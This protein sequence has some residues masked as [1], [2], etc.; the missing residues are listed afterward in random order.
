[1]L[2][3]DRLKKLRN[4]F[5]LTQEE[6]GN[7]INV[8]KASICCYEKG[9]RIPTLQNLIDLSNY[10]EV[11]ID[12]LLGRDVLVKNKITGKNEFISNEE[13]EKIYLT[14]QSKIERKSESMKIDSI[15]EKLKRHEKLTKEEIFYVVN[16]FTNGVIN[17]TKM[18]DF[19]LLIKENGL[20]YE[21]TF[22]LTDAMIKTGDVLDLSNINKTVVDKHSTGGVGDKTTF[23]VGP[24]VASLGL[25]VAKMSGRSLGFTGG[26]IDKLESIPGYTV[27]L[28]NEEFENLVNT[29][30]ISIISQTSSLAPADKKIYALRDEIG[31]VESI[32]LIASSI[33][34]KKIASGAPYIV[35]DLKVGKGAFMKDE[36]SAE[37]LA[38]YMIKIGEYFKR[39][40]VCVLT[41]MST[42]LGYS[43]GN[44]L[45]VKE[46]ENFFLGKREKRLEKLVIELS[47]HMISLGKNISLDEAKKE[48]EKVLT[49]GS[50]KNK[51]YEWI[52]SQHGDL[53]KMLIS[54]KILS[55]KSPKSGYI[56]E[57]NPLEI[58]KIENSLGAGRKKKEDE[59]NRSV[60]INLLHTIYDKIEKDEPL[61]EIYYKDLPADI[62]KKVL[63]LI[64]IESIIEN[65]KDIIISVIK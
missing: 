53:N 19:L 39:K 54:D 40:V 52:N 20:S 28:T 6:L 31:A 50:A 26:T 63:D 8:T 57:I 4:T 3:T 46:A 43:I 16:N 42:P 45:E 33:M 18:G 23:I 7:I 59:I 21:E 64:K 1:M 56:T 62:E 22:Y 35:I 32:P 44:A 51:F 27:N 49:N 36:S 14:Q 13:L 34:S 65:E 41:D 61:M 2:A 58:S 17:D 60:G 24:I 11:S 55:I 12:Y 38:K 10:F 48:V 37:T 15:I 30:G 9:T 25:G 47:S 5:G 29:I